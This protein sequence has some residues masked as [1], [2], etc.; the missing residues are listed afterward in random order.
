MHVLLLLILLPEPHGLGVQAHE[1][2]GVAT[3]QAEA[4]GG[5]MFLLLND[6]VCEGDQLL[7]EAWVVKCLGDV[8]LDLL[9]V[10]AFLARRLARLGPG[11]IDS[12]QEHAY[13]VGHR[14][15]QGTAYLCGGT[16]VYL[17]GARCPFNGFRRI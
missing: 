10:E 12:E 16:L 3:I 7:G 17:E 14:A 11:G 8:A 13:D 9:R 1:V 4:L 2:P 6:L 15:A 5:P